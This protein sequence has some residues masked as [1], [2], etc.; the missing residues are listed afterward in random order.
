M[1]T[2][3][4]ELGKF[5]MKPLADALQE[6]ARIPAKHRVPQRVKLEG[7]LACLPKVGWVKAVVHREIVGKIKTV[8]ISR[9]STGKYYASILGDDGLPEIEPPTHIERVT[10]VDLGLK[11]ALVSS[12]GR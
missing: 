8:T 11:D 5:N 3:P 10:G 12:A 2:F 1:V 9:E 7:N 6:Q 4:V